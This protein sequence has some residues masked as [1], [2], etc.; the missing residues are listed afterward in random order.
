MKDNFIDIYAP[1]IPGRGLG[2]VE[3][4]TH[5][6]EYYDVL[7]NFDWRN[8][9]NWIPECMSSFHVGYK[10][11]NICIMIFD[12]LN[13]KLMKMTALKDY[14]GILLDKIKIGMSLEEALE[15]EENLIYD[16][17]E[18][19]YKIQ[20]VNGVIIEPDAYYKY[21]ESITIYISELDEFQ[22]DFAKSEEIY[23]GKW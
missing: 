11:E 12:I 21:I 5:L 18:E 23:K 10:K 2:G 8:K 14:E 19:C 3:L 16:D 13:G 9:K 1:I 4:R 22:N 7:N 15:K 20:G 17:E 6:N